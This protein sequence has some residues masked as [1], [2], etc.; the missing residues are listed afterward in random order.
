MLRAL[1]VASSRYLLCW[2][3]RRGHHVQ[4]YSQ[5]SLESANLSRVAGFKPPCLSSTDPSAS[6]TSSDHPPP[7]DPQVKSEITCQPS[8]LVIKL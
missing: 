1:I 6:L 5:F 7:Q 4:V 3:C 2:L 8:R